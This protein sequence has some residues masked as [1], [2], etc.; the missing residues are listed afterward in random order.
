MHYGTTSETDMDDIMTEL[1]NWTFTDLENISTKVTNGEYEKLVYGANRTEI[2]F[3]TFVPFYTFKNVLNFNGGNVPNAVFDRIII[4]DIDTKEDKAVIYFVST[5]ER[6]VFES[7]AGSSSLSGFKKYFRESTHKWKP[8]VPYELENSYTL[9]LPQE[10]TIL[11]RY[12]YYPDYIETE[13]FKDALFN[14]PSFVKK[15]TKP[16]SEEY[17][18]GSSLMRVTHDN[19]MVFYVNPAKEAEIERNSNMYQLLE[20]SINFVNEHSGW[21]DQYRLF[22]VS[23]GQPSIGYRLFVNGKPVF[24]GQGMAE[25]MQV[26]GKDQIYKYVRPYFTL[27]ISLP[28]EKEEIRLPDGLTVLKGILNREDIDAKLMEDLAV[29]YKLVHDPE[30]PKILVLEPAWY[31]KYNGKWIQ[32]PDNRE[33]EGGSDG[34]E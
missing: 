10:E 23:P 24:N 7:Q 17:T 29:G 19:N 18:D 13:K 12:K 25:I 6:L 9:F 5:K 2:I 1:R 20:K 15:G 8:Y 14:D 33:S 30:T 32:V 31:Y 27:D 26:W 16:G 28:S 4:T 21:T 11:H 22:D 3:P 34:L